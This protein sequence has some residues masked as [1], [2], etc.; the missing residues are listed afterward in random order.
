MTT[1]CLGDNP[2]SI[3]LIVGSISQ[4]SMALSPGS[5]DLAPSDNSF[6]EISQLN[7]T[8]GENGSTKYNLNNGLEMARRTIKGFVLILGRRH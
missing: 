7:I 5:P 8:Y 6:R 3:M 1:S 2:Q 4:S